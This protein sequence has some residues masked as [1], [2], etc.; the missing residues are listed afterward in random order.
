[1]VKKPAMLMAV[2]GG[3]LLAG[4]EPA[5][6]AKWYPWR[7]SSGGTIFEEPS[8]VS[9]GAGRIDCFARGTSNGLYHRAWTGSSWT[10]WRFLGGYLK[11]GPDCVSWERGRIDRFAIGGDSEIWHVWGNGSSWSSWENLGGSVPE[12]IDG[13]SDPPDCTSWGPKRIDCFVRG[14]DEEMHHRWFDGRWRGW[15]DLQGVIRSAPECAS[16]GR[17]GSTASPAAATARSTTASTAS[18]RRHGGCPS[19]AEPG[20]RGYDARTLDA[21]PPDGRPPEYP[22]V[23]VDRRWS[24]ALDCRLSRRSRSGNEMPRCR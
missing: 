23:P 18:T 20:G 22:S 1:M 3:I 7:A 10:T 8:C 6:A 12:D 4:P 24:P 11:S 5:A 9:W 13:L 16:G 15:E 17:A 2:A 21:E 19:G 14:I